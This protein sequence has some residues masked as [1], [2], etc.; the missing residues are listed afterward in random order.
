MKGGDNVDKKTMIFSGELVDSGVNNSTFKRVKVRVFAFDK[1]ANGSDITRVAFTNAEPSLPLVPMVAK[2][3]EEE[4]NLEGHNQ[5]ITVDKDGKLTIKM[6]TTPFGVV[7]ENPTITFEDIDEN[8]V[9]KTYIVIDNVYLWK[10]Y[11]ATQKIIEWF[12]QGITPKISME[13]GNVSGSLKDGYFV[14]DSF[15]FQAI[16]ALGLG[17]A[18]CFPNADIQEYTLKFE[19]DY[20]EMV[21]ELRKDLLNQSS[22]EVDINNEQG[23]NRMENENFSLSA[24]NLEKA[25]RNILSERK[26]MVRDYW[27]DVYEESEFYY[28][29]RKDGH[30]IVISNDWSTYYGIPYTENNDTVTLDF[31]NKIPYVSDWR[32]LQEGETAPTTFAKEELEAKFSVI[33]EKSKEKAISEFSVKDTEDYKGLETQFNEV[34]DTNKTLTDKCLDYEKTIEENTTKFSAIEEELNSL[35]QFKKKSDDNDK[36]IK[37]D[38]LFSKFEKYMSDEIKE[39]KDK[40]MELDFAQLETSLYTIV[41]KKIVEN[42][43]FSAKEDTKQTIEMGLETF[44]DNSNSKPYEGILKKYAK[45]SEK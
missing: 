17:V 22:Y 1:N 41:G 42:N 13:I 31:D 33:V 25:I 36:Q 35:R 39:L 18:P 11:E 12:E 6:D 2:Y 23:G 21:S 30:V 9:I 27:G 37:I 8:G 20:R 38:T 16:T 26:V 4:D 34:Q 32:P 10:R 24:E 3:N 29:D 45:K 43:I 14:I 40:A 5:V 19:K 7:G 44:E 15:E 28:R